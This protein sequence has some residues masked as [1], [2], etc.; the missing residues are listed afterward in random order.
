[1]TLPFHIAIP[2]RMGSTRLPGKPLVMLAGRPLIS[3]V[4]ERARGCGA[5]QILVAVDDPRVAAV[6]EACGARAIPTRVDHPTGSDRLAEL[7]DICG[8]DDEEIVVNLQGDEPLTPL[9]A[10][11]L[12][13]DALAALNVPMSTLAVPLTSCRE[14]FDPNIVKVVCRADQRALMFSRAPLPWSRDRFNDDRLGPPP[15]GALRHIGMYGYRAGALRRF[16][17]LPPGVLEMEESLEQLRALE[18]GW[19][20][21]IVAFTAPVPAGLDTPDD[22]V[23]LDRL[24]S[25]PRNHVNSDG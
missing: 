13:A 12:L 22:A 14:L 21:A 1:M 15:A 19:D 20:I 3:W 5:D 18:A 17:Q 11:R 10:P 24:L 16:R 4:I 25:D 2:A 6:V 8:L 23:R 9:A 7:V